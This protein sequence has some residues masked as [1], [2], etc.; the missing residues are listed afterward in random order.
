MAAARSFAGLLLFASAHGQVKRY[1]VV[2]E[3]VGP[4]FFKSW[5]FY[6]GSDP[7]HGTVNFVTEEQ[8][9]Q[10]QLLS[11][12]EYGVEMRA[13]S[14]TKLGSEGGRKA[15]R[16]ESKNS[17]NS[18]LFVLSLDHVPT[19]CGAWP[20]FWMFGDDA[21]HSWPRWGEYDILESIHTLNYATTTLHTR[22]SCDQRDVNN[23]IDFVGQGWAAGSLGN[24]KAKNCWVKAPQEYDNQGCGQKLPAG[25]FGEGFNQ[26][27]GGTFVAE[28]DREDRKF[29]RTWFFPKGKEPIDLIVRSPEPDLWGTPNSF[30]TLHERWCT[31]DHFKNMRMVFDTTFCG[32]YAGSTFAAMCPSIKTTCE[33]YV[34]NHPEAFSETFWNIQRLDV[35]QKLDGAQLAAMAPVDLVEERPHG[36][37]VATFLITLTLLVAAG[38]AGYYFYHKN[39]KVKTR[40]DDCIEA[41]GLTETL[42]QVQETCH[43][44]WQRMKDSLNPRGESDGE[45]PPDTPVTSPRALAAAPPP[46]QSGSP[47]PGLAGQLQNWTAAASYYA[48]SLRGS[49]AVPAGGSFPSSNNSSLQRHAAAQP[50]H[51]DVPMPLMWQPARSRELSGLVPTPS[52]RQ[53]SLMHHQVSHVSS[54]RV[55]ALNSGSLPAV[56]HTS[57]LTTQ[58][59]ATR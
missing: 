8:A 38:A 23:G 4:D 50:D 5:N 10:S 46:K 22:E 18:G 56:S 35:Y 11:A 47:T 54:G 9:W 42:Q 15:V 58:R 13:D 16:I 36:H 45:T 14:T 37:G 21:Q 19:A 59:P 31:A 44:G 43:G 32:D 7:T 1:H 39:D 12:S 28:W 2:E 34:R 17:Y 30:F 55:Q 49:P 24:N 52:S 57:S 33:D 48:S 25:S 27:G 6:S 41:A 26:N 20:A 53:S 3:F 51:H 40:V 29:M